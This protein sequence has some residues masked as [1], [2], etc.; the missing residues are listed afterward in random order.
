MNETLTTD[1]H[2]HTRARA[3]KHART[4]SRTSSRCSLWS[5]HDIIGANRESELMR[6]SWTA[7]AAMRCAL[8]AGA[9]W[10]AWCSGTCM[11]TPG[12]TRPRPLGRARLGFVQWRNF[13]RDPFTVFLVGSMFFLSRVGL[14]LG[15]S[16]L[17]LLQSRSSELQVLVLG[18]RASRSG[19]HTQADLF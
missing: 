18:G 8:P 17:I 19:K 7:D 6:S 13:S 2:T 12:S 3:R 1:V 16:V 4:C 15:Y 5:S 9:A 14:E 11:Q 10:L